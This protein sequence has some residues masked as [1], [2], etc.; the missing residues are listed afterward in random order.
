MNSRTVVS[1][2]RKSSYSGAGEASECVEVAHTADNGRAVRD[3]KDTARGTAYFGAGAWRAFT[4]HLR[5]GGA[6]GV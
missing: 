4:A 5:G 2:F 6:G 3:S 1:R